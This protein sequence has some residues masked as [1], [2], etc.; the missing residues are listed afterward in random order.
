MDAWHEF[1]CSE[2]SKPAGK[3]KLEGKGAAAR[4]VVSSFTGRV[5]SQVRP[6]ALSAVESA[7]SEGDIQT[8]FEIDLEYAPFYCLS[9]NR[10]YCD[11]HWAFWDVFEEDG[12]FDATRGVCPRGHERML[13]D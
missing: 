13:S 5:E 12:W 4:L 9:C 8:L 7:L 3:L 1:T 2:C 6:E 11:E 10:C